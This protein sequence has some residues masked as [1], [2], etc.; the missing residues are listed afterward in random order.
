MSTRS[1]RRPV[2]LLVP[3]LPLLAP[4]AAWSQQPAPESA[5]QAIE[6][7]AARPAQ[8]A[9][10]AAA[11]AG[12]A[13][14]QRRARSRRGAFDTTELTLSGERSIELRFDQPTIEDPAYAAIQSPVEGEIVQFVRSRPLKLKTPVDLRFG[15]TLVEAHNHGPEYPG[16]Y[17]LWLRNVGGQWRLVFNHLADVWGTQHDPAED[18]AEVPLET[19]AAAEPVKS[20]TAELEPAEGG[21]VLRLAWGTSVW[22]V[23]FT[24]P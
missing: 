16:V 23:P 2:V 14:D 13:P 4:A 12:G 10:S 17:S 20:F 6:Q 11:E 5:P 22:T 8:Q 15:D 3:I 21:G 18:A 19:A 7:P 9:G 24:A 1:A